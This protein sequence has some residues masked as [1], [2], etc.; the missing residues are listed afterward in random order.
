M[1][2]PKEYSGRYFFHFTHVDNIE[3][4][5]STNGLLSTNIKQR[6]GISHH[7]VA[8]MQI[9]N[10]RSE[11]LVTVKPGGLVHDYVPFYFASTNK[12]LLGLLNRKIVD[13]PY[14]VFIAI[15][16]D[17]LLKEN[18]I[19]TDKSAN[20][21]IPPNFYSNPDDLNKLRWD[22]I[23]STKWS[24]KT[25]ELNYRMAEVLIHNHVP[26]EWIDS[27]IVFNDICKNKIKTTYKNAGLATPTISFNWF[28]NR[29]YFFTKFMFSGR[30]LETLVTGPLQLHEIYNNLINYILQENANNKKDKYRFTDIKSMLLGIKLNFCVLPELEGI[31][32]LETDNQV[33]HQSVSD[34]TLSVVKEVKECQYYTL[35]D[36]KDK[37]IVKLAAYLHDIGKGPKEK[38]NKGIQK[39]Y[40]DHPAD[41]IPM[42]ARI[43]TEEIKNIDEYEV[44]GIC[45]LVIYH[46]LLGDIIGKE[47]GIQE[48][49]NLNLNINELN[50]LAT[51][52]EAD[53]SAINGYHDFSL[54]CRISELIDSVMR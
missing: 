7:N 16:I 20:T 26:L 18:V 45:L 35:L 34:H 14:I 49:Y 21:H 29:S 53:I 10:T 19:F 2:I 43:L 41:S 42:L 11:M 33:H 24:E 40:P 39:A 37:N 27:Y 54:N 28:N 23:D 50:I 52:S 8:N 44:K 22:L 6:K 36:E 17:K 31:F 3:S 4:I 46:D 30:E 48:L 25:G 47:R 12:M 5:V 15:S 1:S 32:N 38:W 9:Q 51:I 13:Q